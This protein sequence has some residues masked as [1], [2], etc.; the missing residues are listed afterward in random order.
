VLPNRVFPA[1]FPKTQPLPIRKVVKNLEI[2]LSGCGVL[3]NPQKRQVNQGETC[4]KPTEFKGG[5]TKVRRIPW[6]TFNTELRQ[7]LAAIQGGG[8][9]T[10][11]AWA[12]V[13]GHL[14]T[15]SYRSLAPGQARYE[16]RRDLVA[17][18]LLH[19]QDPKVFVKVCAAVA[20]AQ[21]LDKM[22][23]NRVREEHHETSQLARWLRRLAKAATT[24]PAESP[25]W[26]AQQKDL[27]EKV[28]EVAARVLDE[29]DCQALHWF[30]LDELPAS[31]IA[32]R[33]KC[34]ESAVWKRL[35]RARNRIREAFPKK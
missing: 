9:S 13:K 20:P 29:D 8:S 10:A 5:G 28:Q 2:F 15:L 14:S 30:Y 7:A 6:R 1:T 18:A 19:L 26:K 31:E 4:T 25:A 23:L 12:V 34:T 35:S 11:W 16:D 32:S 27:V 22:L 17:W 21:Y 33:L 24:A 3:T